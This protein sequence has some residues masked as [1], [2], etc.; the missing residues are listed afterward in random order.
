MPHSLRS[1]VAVVSTA[2]I[3]LVGAAVL[4]A[5]GELPGRVDALLVLFAVAIL[6]AEL[7]PLDIPGHE[8]QATFSTTFAFALLLAEGT[9]VVVLTHVLCVVVA[10]L[11]RRRPIEKLVFNAAQYALSWGAAGGVVALG[12]SGMPHLGGPEHLIVQRAP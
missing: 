9:T 12:G 3:A 8:G 1:F 6:V 7:F 4:R 5:P 10:D 11:L 2:G